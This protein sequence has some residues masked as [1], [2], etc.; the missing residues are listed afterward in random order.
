[1]EQAVRVAPR[2]V[3]G[4]VP[5]AERLVHAGRPALRLVGTVRGEVGANARDDERHEERTHAGVLA[6]REGL[7]AGG[8]RRPGISSD[9]H[10]LREAPHRWQEELD[11]LGVPGDLE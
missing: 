5:V 1:M 3:R 9:E 2:R 7:F 6:D 11:L 8:D 4:P 10:G